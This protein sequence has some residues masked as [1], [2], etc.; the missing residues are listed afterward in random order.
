ME[1]KAPK[2][3]FKLTFNR[4]KLKFHSYLT[5]LDRIEQ[6]PTALKPE[7][8]DFFTK[9]DQELVLQN[10]WTRLVGDRGAIEL[11]VSFMARTVPFPGY[12]FAPLE[13]CA[14]GV[15]KLPV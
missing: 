4:F 2:E 3:E 5:L 7:Q 13:P 11:V 8:V 15:C 12:S 14:A 10:N 6:Q 1:K 9:V